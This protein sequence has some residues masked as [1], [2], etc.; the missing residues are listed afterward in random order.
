MNQ[1][2]ISPKLLQ[3]LGVELSEQD[4]SHLNEDVVAELNRRVID[5]VISE[6]EPA[7]LE[8]LASNDPGS[9]TLLVWL[10]VNV[11]QFSDIVAEE[12]VMLLD[13]IVQNS[14]KLA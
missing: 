5:Q 3:K 13:D 10:E 2:I 4:L 8:E 11:P 6:L 9:D 1:Q 12:T 7:Q 14:E